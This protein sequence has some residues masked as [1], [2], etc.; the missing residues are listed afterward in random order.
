[1]S[2][3]CAVYPELLAINIGRGIDERYI[4]LLYKICDKDSTLGVFRFRG[5]RPLTRL[6]ALFRFTC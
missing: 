6:A 3:A 1:M 2:A 4:C 5:Y